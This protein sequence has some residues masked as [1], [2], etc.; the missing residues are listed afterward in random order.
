MVK[1]RSDRHDAI[2]LIVR[3]REIRTQEDLAEELQGAGFACGQGTVSRDMS[4]VGLRKV[5]NGTYVLPED[6]ALQRLASEF[7][8]SCEHAGQ[9]VAI[10]CTRGVED[11]VAEAVD[12]SCLPGAMCAVTGPGSVLVACRSEDDARWVSGFVGRLR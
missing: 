5:S 4:E 2:R 11:A 9:L 3:G 1:Q 12:A 6:A 10:R 8:D 7:V